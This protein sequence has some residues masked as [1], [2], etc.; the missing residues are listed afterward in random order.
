LG[1]YPTLFSLRVE[2]LTPGIEIYYQKMSIDSF[3]VAT[4]PATGALLFPRGIA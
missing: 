3:L 1:I 2:E 4:K